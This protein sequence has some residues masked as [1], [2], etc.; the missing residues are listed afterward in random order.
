MPFASC[1]CVYV[2]VDS[3]FSYVS[4]VCVACTH[5]CGS[6]CAHVYTF[7]SQQV[8][9]VT[10]HLFP[11]DSVPHWPWSCYRSLPP[12]ALSY[13]HMW[14]P[15]LSMCWGFEFR[16]LR[17]RSKLFIHWTMSSAHVL[18]VWF[19]ISLLL[20]L[21]LGNSRQCIVITFTLFS[22]LLSDLAHPSLPTQ[23]CVLFN[24]PLLVSF[25]H[26]LALQFICVLQFACYLS[27][28]RKDTLLAFYFWRLDPK[29][30]ASDQLS[31]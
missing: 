26:W 6:T 5:A 29:L 15:W 16:S 10:F 8:S 13:R 12:T 21:F 23:V 3:V 7:G 4:V 9:S 1:L 31:G 22:Q 14:P 2:C 30:Q 25:C 20:E 17:L 19:L 27:A 18:T 11:W 24:A 28:R